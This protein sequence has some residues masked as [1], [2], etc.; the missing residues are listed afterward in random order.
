MR[1][2]VPSAPLGSGT[3]S[4]RR[5]MWL[6]VAVSL[7]PLAFVMAGLK[8]WVPRETALG[9][10]PLLFGCLG[11]AGWMGWQAHQQALADSAR[12]GGQAMILVIAAQLKTQDEPTLQRIASK[13][14]PAGEAA[15]WILQGRR[16]K[17]ASSG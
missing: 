14:G 3:R 6:I 4:Y 9:A 8:G 13:K 7:L 16:E 10:I 5:F 15:T 11:W 1:K 17:R 12:A 2:P